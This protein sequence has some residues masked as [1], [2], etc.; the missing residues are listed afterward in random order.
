MSDPVSTVDGHSYERSAITNWLKKNDTSP[1]TMEKLPSKTLTRNHALRGAID[2]WR[3]RDKASECALERN[4]FRKLKHKV[5]SNILNLKF[6]LR[7]AKSNICQHKENY[8]KAPKEVDAAVERTI[9]QVNGV[10]HRQRDEIATS[11]KESFCT[12][13]K[14]L[15]NEV[16]MLSK[17]LEFHKNTYK[18]TVNLFGLSDPNVAQAQVEPI[19]G[20]ANSLYTEGFD[21]QH[22]T[23][24]TEVSSITA[25]ADKR[26]IDQSFR[27]LAYSVNLTVTNRPRLY[28]YTESSAQYAC[29]QKIKPNEAF[30]EGDAVVFRM[31]PNLPRGLKL[32]TTTGVL[33]GTPTWD[34]SWTGQEVQSER[35][36]VIENDAGSSKFTLKIAIVKDRNRKQNHNR[37]C[38]GGISRNE[39]R[40]VHRN[41]SS[42]AETCTTS[43][44][45]NSSSK[46]IFNLKRKAAVV[47]AVRIKEYRPGGFDART[48]FVTVPDFCRR[49]TNDYE[50]GHGRQR[51][52]NARP[53]ASGSANGLFTNESTEKYEREKAT[54]PAKK[55][56]LNGE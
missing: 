8:E 46:A 27:G 39:M 4:E 13:N 42:A 21:P 41:A 36:V 18:S 3:Q 28:G 37:V 40:N 6:L 50:C 14:V 12:T 29:G 33:S 31:D 17:S 53:T 48:R 56:R 19:A 54:G 16:S 22:V 15:V 7:S 45:G 1:L 38:T 2:E 32:D 52:R 43:A 51:M 23:R 20:A 5:E 25:H 44:D 30:Y 24:H 47:D 11:M 9:T 49:H 55:K 34:E 26:P 10:L 35:T